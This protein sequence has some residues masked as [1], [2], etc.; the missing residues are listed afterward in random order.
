MERNGLPGPPS[1]ADSL[2]RVSDRPLISTSHGTRPEAFGPTEWL[3]LAS[4]ALIWG[5]SFVFIVIGLDAFAPG[6]VTTLRIVFGAACL[7]LVGARR[8]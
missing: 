2:P 7:A 5:S 1:G 3:L 4:I 8:G 6:L